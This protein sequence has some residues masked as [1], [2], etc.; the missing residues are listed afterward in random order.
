MEKRELG[1]KGEQIAAFYL[2]NLGYRIIEKNFRTAWG[3]IDLIAWEKQCLVFLEVKTRTSLLYG[4]P[5]EAV[6]KR[7]Q[8]KIRKLAAY[9]LQK[10][11]IVDTNCRFDVVLL[12]L[13]K[14]EEIK[15]IEVITQA[16]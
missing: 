6:D 10:K 4:S 8:E 11:K 16:F 3:E 2:E 5:A 12:L 9:Y 15:K 14:K 13:N 7:K 1:T